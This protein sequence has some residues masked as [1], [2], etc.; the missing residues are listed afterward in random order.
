MPAFIL[1]MVIATSLC[2]TTLISASYE[3]SLQSKESSVHVPEKQSY[4]R[5]STEE[6]QEEV[7]KRSREGNLPFPMGVE[8]IKRWTK[9]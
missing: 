8:L 7:E 3:I 1:F 4:M 2:T 6:L 5:M 9:K